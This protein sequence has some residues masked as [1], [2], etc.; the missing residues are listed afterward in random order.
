MR[1]A[2]IRTEYDDR[3]EKIG[4][5]IREAQVVDRVPYMLVIGQQESDNGTVAV[6]FRDTAETKSMPLDEFVATVSEEIRT[7]K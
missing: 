5:K 3:N 2:K 4:Y 7:R 6:R 1:A